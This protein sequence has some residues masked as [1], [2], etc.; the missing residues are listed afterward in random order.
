M[1]FFFYSFFPV[2]LFFNGFWLSVPQQLY[3]LV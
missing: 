2:L 3:F 1:Q